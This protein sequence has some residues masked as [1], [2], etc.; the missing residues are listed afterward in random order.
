MQCGYNITFIFRNMKIHTDST[1]RLQLTFSR[2]LELNI[3]ATSNEPPRA[4]TTGTK[5]R[6]TYWM[7]ATGAKDA[8][9]ATKVARKGKM[10]AVMELHVT[11]RSYSS[12][13]CS[14]GRLALCGHVSLPH[15]LHSWHRMHANAKPT[16]QPSRKA[17]EDDEYEFRRPQEVHGVVTF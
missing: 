4:P 14:S 15:R 7:D 6:S 11:A 8:T 9:D 2:W 3:T 17:L 10:A 13:S 5:L 16:G 1:S 12:C